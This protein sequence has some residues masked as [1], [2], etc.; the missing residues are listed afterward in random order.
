MLLRLHHPLEV[1]ARKGGCLNDLVGSKLSL[2]A[3]E[4]WWEYMAKRQ[5]R[6]LST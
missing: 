5:A 2:N 3:G 6:Y 4:C 1:P